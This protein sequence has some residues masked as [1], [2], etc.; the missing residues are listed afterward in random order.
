MRTI[1]EIAA[2]MPN[3]KYFPILDASSGF[4]QV[5]IDHNSANHSQ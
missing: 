5:K 2:R 3:A 4:W 1:Q